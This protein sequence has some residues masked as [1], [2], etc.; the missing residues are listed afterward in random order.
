MGVAQGL[1]VL[2]VHLEEKKTLQT[3]CWPSVPG[4]TD[5]DSKGL[6]FVL[7]PDKGKDRG[8]TGVEVRNENWKLWQ[9]SP[10][11]LWIPYLVSKMTLCGGG[12][13]HSHWVYIE[14][15]A[16]GSAACEQ[17]RI[18]KLWCDRAGM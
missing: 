6:I 12:G 3:G 7:D 5:P 11:P 15:G 14:T 13:H 1:G 17:P 9:A 2:K 16:E 8:L 10:S 4:L 18:T